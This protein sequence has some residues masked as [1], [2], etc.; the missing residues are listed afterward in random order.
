[1][2]NILEEVTRVRLHTRNYVKL[3]SLRTKLG[4]GPVFQ[5]I[6]EV[7]VPHHTRDSWRKVDLNHRSLDY[8]PSGDD[9]APLFRYSST[10]FNHHPSMCSLGMTI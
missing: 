3:R 4:P 7:S 8:E 2:T 10:A 5:Q 1:M 6:E 9:L